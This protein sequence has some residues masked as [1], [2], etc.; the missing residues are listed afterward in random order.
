MGVATVSMTS[1]ELQYRFVFPDKPV[2]SII[3]AWM[4]GGIG[5]CFNLKFIGNVSCPIFRNTTVSHSLKIICPIP[6]YSKNTVG[7]LSLHAQTHTYIYIYI[8]VYTVHIHIHAHKLT[9]PFF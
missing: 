6:K 7:T 4:K 2:N 8:Y 1:T 5:K 9:M 3:A